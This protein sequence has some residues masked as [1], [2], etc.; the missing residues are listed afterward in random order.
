MQDEV[1]GIG[2]FS[3]RGSGNGKDMLLS[4]L[5]DGSICIWSLK[6]TASGKG[7]R[8]VARSRPGLVFSDQGDEKWQVRRKAREAEIVDGMSVDDVTGKVWVAGEEGLIEID[9]NTLQKVSTHRFPF[10]I[11]T[12]SQTSHPHPL[13]VGTTLTLHLHDP[14]V[15]VPAS[16]VTFSSGGTDDERVQPVRINPQPYTS[17]PFRKNYRLHATLFQPGPLSIIHSDPWAGASSGDGEIYVAGRFPSILCYSRKMWP[18]LRGTIYSGGRLCALASIPY[19]HSPI[20]PP[21]PSSGLGAEVEAEDDRGQTTLLAAGEYKGHGTLEV[22]PLTSVPSSFPTTLVP[23]T[24]NATQNRQTAS[25][26]KVMT[27][28]SHGAR[29]VTGDGNGIVKWFERD[30]RKLARAYVVEPPDRRKKS[31][32]LWESARATTAAATGRGLHMGGGIGDEVIRKV[33]VVNQGGEEL[34][35]WAGDRVGVLGTFG[36]EEAEVEAEEENVEKVYLRKMR[37]VLERQA[38]EV[39]IMA[40]LGQF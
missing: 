6:D 10:S 11:T 34:I 25:R 28:A 14:R 29:I 30:G 5:S 19:F 36:A 23:T 13:T 16:T 2:A 24:T 32:G 26:S 17:H 31:E 8:I 27:V 12:L 7:R 38:E 40:G 3:S 15:A 20:F 39:R 4:S 21:G 18:K 1:K 35:V 9:L 33:I 37:E 22:Y